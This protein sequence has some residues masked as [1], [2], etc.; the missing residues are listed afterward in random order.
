MTNLPPLFGAE[1][2][3]RHYWFAD[4]LAH[5]VFGVATLAFAVCL[6]YIRRGLQLHKPWGTELWI[7]A[8]VA[9]ALLQAGHRHVVEWLKTKTT[10]PRTGYAAASFP[11]DS[12]IPNDVDTLFTQQAR[13]TMA[14][15]ASSMVG[16]LFGD[17]TGL[18]AFSLQQKSA[19][20]GRQPRR[21]AEGTR[22]MLALALVLLGCLVLLFVEETWAWVAVGA[23]IGA[24]AWVV[25][26]LYRLSWWIVL[27][28]PVMV[29]NM[30]IFLAAH[31]TRSDCLSCF[32]AAWGFLFL[33]DGA[34]A[35]IRYLQRNPMPAEPTA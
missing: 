12:T 14:Y 10:Y 30:S 23:M 25:R 21:R 29:L 33:L 19:D 28:F 8:F 24:A 20:A 32:L 22:Q 13:P 31:V 5:I 34:I 18:V 9:Y 17:P 16:A 3:A 6:F 4:G 35:L 26:E 2:R 27:G 7:G 11:G 15:Q 1:Q